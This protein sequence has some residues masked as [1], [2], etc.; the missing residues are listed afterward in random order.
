MSGSH[1]ST[2]STSPSPVTLMEVTLFPISLSYLQ[3]PGLESSRCRLS[4]FLPKLIGFV[5]QLPVR[6]DSTMKM[7]A[8]AINGTGDGR[9]Y[10]VLRW[11]FCFSQYSLSIPRMHPYQNPICTLPH[12]WLFFPY[13]HVSHRLEFF[14]PLSDESLKQQLDSLP[15]SSYWKAF[16]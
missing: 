14:Q 16:Y 15:V 5:L 13:S 4:I 11:F 3:H 1:S 6:V 7:N 10:K 8:H 9:T 12:H 2:R